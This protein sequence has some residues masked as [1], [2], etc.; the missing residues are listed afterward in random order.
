[1]AGLLRKTTM[2]NPTRKLASG[3][4]YALLCVQALLAVTALAAVLFKERPQAPHT[5]YLAAVTSEDVAWR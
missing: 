3:I 4:M 5:T 1:M 2:T